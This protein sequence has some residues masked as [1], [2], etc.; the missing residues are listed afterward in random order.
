MNKS[1]N[2]LTKSVGRVSS[3]YAT[4]NDHALYTKMYWSSSNLEMIHLLQQKI[5]LY[6]F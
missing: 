5:F 4:Q 2:A 1:E 3:T 6:L